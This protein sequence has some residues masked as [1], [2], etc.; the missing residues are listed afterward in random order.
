[1]L[2]LTPYNLNNQ[3]MDATIDL[4]KQIIDRGVNVQEV[5]IDTIGQPDAYRR[6]L[7]R[8]FPTLKITVEKKADSLYAC[9]GAASVVAKVT[10]DASCEV[11]WSEY[12]RSQSITTEVEDTPTV[13]R[14]KTIHDSS[15]ADGKTNHEPEED[16][17]KPTSSTTDIL[18][19]RTRQEEPTWGSGYPSDTRCTTWLRNSMDPLFGWGNECR[20]SWGTAKDMLEAK[21]GGTKCDWP[22]TGEEESNQLSNYFSFSGDS[23]IEGVRTE[24]DELRTWFGRGV[25]VDAF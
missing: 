25:S 15:S 14:Q 23:H 18:E 10:R 5:Y 17:H 24:A 16:L 4:I 21:G 3:A 7:E 1:M 19:E 12:Q 11:L 2:K 9:V 22:N 6:K 20:F 8:V 13:K